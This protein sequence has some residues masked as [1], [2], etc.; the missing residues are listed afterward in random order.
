MKISI[1][2]L[3]TQTAE[4]NTILQKISMVLQNISLDN[5]NSLTLEGKCGIIDSNSG[6]SNTVVY[7]NK[8]QLPK[9]VFI[10]EG[11][12]TIPYEGIGVNTI[13]VQ[14]RNALESFT[15]IAVF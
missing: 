10:Q 7:F 5:T 9:F 11:D 14:S 15:L 3:T 6:Y 1:P 13:K 2:Y 12:I 4:L 8:N